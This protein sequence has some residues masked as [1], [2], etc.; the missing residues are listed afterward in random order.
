M[1]VPFLD[2]KAPYLELKEELDA[3]Y[4]RVMESGWYILGQEVEAFEEEFAVYCETKYCVGVGNGLES[5]HLILRAMEIGA[6]DEVIV[7]ANTYIATWLAVS[8]A[9][10]IPV[11]VEPDINTYN[12]DCKKIEAAITSRT[13][14]IIAV[15]LYGQPADMDFIN[16]IASRHNLKVIEDAAQ[17][18]GARYKNRRVGS[19][20][21]AAGFS[22]YPG[23]NLGAFGDGGAVTTSDANLADKI[24]LLRNYGSRVKYENEVKGFN[25]RLD[26][27]QAAFLRVK[28][29]KLDE[30][31]ERRKQIAIYY[32]QSLQ[33]VVDLKLPYVSEW[34]EPVWHLFVITHPQRDNLKNHLDTSGI[35]SLIH[36][37][38]P[39]HLSKAYIDN[40]WTRGVLTITENI[41][42]RIISLPMGSHISNKLLDRVIEVLQKWASSSK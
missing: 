13:K 31:N 25:S 12:I 38:I 21:D 32:L 20:G 10:A 3:A 2:L 36:Y 9:G 27:L 35:G 24:R 29:T 28:L 5:L 41:S 7:P 1:K 19:L 39:P 22:F 34:A 23:K 26:E 14:A 16:E 15:H 30:W 42:T 17:A 8:Y 37:P 18:H 4:Q 6:G 11:A 40:E 33:E